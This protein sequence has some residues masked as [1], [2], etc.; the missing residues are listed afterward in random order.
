MS[1]FHRGNLVRNTKTP[2]RVLPGVYRVPVMTLSVIRRPWWQQPVAR[3]LA[4]CVPASLLLWLS[5]KSDAWLSGVLANAGVTV[6]L[7]VPAALYADWHQRAL[8]DVRERTEEA[9]KD[10]RAAKSSAAGSA[11]DVETLSGALD[12]LAGMEAIQEGVREAQLH[13]LAGH[14]SLFDAWADAADRANAIRALRHA[15]SSSLISVRGY[16]VP[17]AETWLHLR[18]AYLDPH[19]QLVLTIERDDGSP[20]GQVE[21]YDGVAP[22]DVYL[23]LDQ[24]V[25]DAGQQPGTGWALSTHAVKTAALSLRHAELERATPILHGDNFRSLVQFTAS[26]ADDDTGWYITERT[27]FPVANAYYV[28]AVDRLDELDWDVHLSHKGWHGSGRALELARA[29]RA[30]GIVR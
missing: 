14:L 5:Y 25:K 3:V 17:L 6:L 23:Q 13:Q 20:V 19:E 18:F 26:E 21:W 7:L 8:L 30:A 24:I 2:P 27:L 28:V 10:A 12:R 1:V 29:L 15:T 9:R 4:T 16:R 11:A 22:V